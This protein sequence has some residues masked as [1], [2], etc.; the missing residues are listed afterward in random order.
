MCLRLWVV[1][2]LDRRGDCRRVWP[3]QARVMVHVKVGLRC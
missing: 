2:G 3:G 1:A